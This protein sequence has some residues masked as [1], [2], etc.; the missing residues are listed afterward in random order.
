MYLAYVVDSGVSDD[1]WRD[2]STTCERDKEL[3]SKANRLRRQ[4]ADLER[5]AVARGVLVDSSAISTCAPV[6]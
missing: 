4:L 1:M 3:R 6:D 5:E 2:I